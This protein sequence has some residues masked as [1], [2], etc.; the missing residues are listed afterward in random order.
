MPLPYGPNR[1]LEFRLELANKIQRG[2]AVGNL[3]GVGIFR[4]G[5]RCT[6]ALKPQED[7]Q[8]ARDFVRSMQSLADAGVLR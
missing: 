1:R 2:R 7:E 4:D 6:W 3:Y 5:S 8:V